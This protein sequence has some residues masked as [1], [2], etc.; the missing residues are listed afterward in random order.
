[1]PLNNTERRRRLRQLLKTIGFVFRAD[2]PTDELERMMKFIEVYGVA[3]ADKP[4]YNRL[5]SRILGGENDG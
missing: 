1:M 3:T 2:T 5:K 4:E